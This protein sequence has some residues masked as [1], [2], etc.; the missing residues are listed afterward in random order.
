MELCVNEQTN[1]VGR[2]DQIEDHGAA[3]TS[4][5]TH[6]CHWSHSSSSKAPIV[7]NMNLCVNNPLAFKVVSL[8]ILKYV[9]QRHRSVDRP[10][11][12]ARMIGRTVTEISNYFCN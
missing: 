4:G 11:G 7:D 8:E 3:S 6:Q 2:G 1:F 10:D 12:I 5:N 9:H